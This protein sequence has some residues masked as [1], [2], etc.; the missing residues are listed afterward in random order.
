MRTRALVLTEEPLCRPCRAK[1]RVTVSEEVDHIVPLE[2]GGTDARENLQGICG[3]CHKVK[4]GAAPR[5]GAD[6]WP[7]R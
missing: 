5:I 4:H 7:V 3:D 2:H 1:G 6:G